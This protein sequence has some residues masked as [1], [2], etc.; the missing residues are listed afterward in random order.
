MKKRTGSQ[1]R[2][3]L[4]E[5]G[6][7]LVRRLGPGEIVIDNHDDLEV[8]GANDN[9]AGYTLQVGRWGYEFLRDYHGD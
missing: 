3:T 6:C 2:E 1:I 8:W 5:T 9:H 4:K 7:K